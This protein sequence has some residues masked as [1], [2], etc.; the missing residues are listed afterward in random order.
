MAPPV[1][2]LVLVPSTHAVSIGATS[3]DNL[4]AASNPN[5]SLVSAAAPALPDCIGLARHSNSFRKVLSNSTSGA[6]IS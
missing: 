1:L 5:R 3:T 6:G 4:S 2:L